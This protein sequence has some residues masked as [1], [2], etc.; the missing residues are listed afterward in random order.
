MW[1]P[2]TFSNF[3]WCGDWYNR[4]GK[5]NYLI[6]WFNKRGARNKR[7]GA[8]FGAFLI[9]MVAEITEL[10][11]ENSQ[12]INC[13]GIKLCLRFLLICFVRVIK[14]FFYQSSLGNEVDFKDIMNIFLNILAKIKI[15]KSERQFCR[16]KSTDS[17]SI[18]IFLSLE[19]LCTKLYH[20]KQQ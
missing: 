9:N 15:S 3:A 16:W 7:G 11:V 8:K 10:R 6:P 4:V 13:Y 2:K 5:L 20:P 19:N 14:G 18:N 1:K 17:N 12:K